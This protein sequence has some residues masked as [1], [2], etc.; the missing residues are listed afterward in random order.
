[1][2]ILHIWDQAGVSCIMAKYQRKIGHE[3]QVIKPEQNDQYGFLT[4]YNETHTDC[5]CTYFD[6]FAVE[7]AY[8]FDIIHCHSVHEIATTIKT[9]YPNKKV[10][11]HYHGSDLRTNLVN[12]FANNLVDGIFYATKDL[13]KYLPQRAIYIP[14]IVDR[15]L[16]VWNRY[17][18]PGTFTRTPGAF[19]LYKDTPKYYRQFDTFI[20]NRVVLGQ[21]MTELSKMAYECLSLGLKVIDWRGDTHIGLGKEH[22]PEEV[23]K[24]LDK[25]YGI[26]P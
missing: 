11:I 26:S 1:M 25:Y 21:Q 13:A 7:L 4:Y 6:D 16:F 2:K 9:L 12:E 22:W 18:G 19:Y 14:T 3:V 20:D 5:G 17:N 8:R 23:V 24:L 15:E 10:F